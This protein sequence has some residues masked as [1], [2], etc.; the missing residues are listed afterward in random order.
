[1]STAAPLVSWLPH[2]EPL[3]Y[4]MLTAPLSGFEGT[5]VHWLLEWAKSIIKDSLILLRYL[6]FVYTIIVFIL[7][8]EGK[9]QFLFF[10]RCWHLLQKDHGWTSFVLILD[11]G[12][13][14]FRWELAVFLI[15]V[16]INLLNRSSFYY[17]LNRRAMQSSHIWTCIL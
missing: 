17:A 16:C 14:Y 2:T 1:M 3:M 11:V 6:L 13:H 8:I 10:S 4:K 5:I 12:L 9:M 15:T 7:I